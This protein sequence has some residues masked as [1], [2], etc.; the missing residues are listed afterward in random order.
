MPL[1]PEKQKSMHR[2]AGSAAL[3]FALVTGALPLSAADISTLKSGDALVLM[4]AAAHL[5]TDGRDWVVPLH[6]WVYV[7]QKSRVRR[8]AIE[9]LLALRYG[10]TSSPA[11]A[12]YLTSRVNLL[13]ADNKRGRRI[14]V[15]VGGSRF[16]LPPT[17][18][19]GHAEMLARVPVSAAASDGGRLTIRAAL[20]PGDTR[21]I[22]TSVHLI[23]LTGTS[24]ISDI[25]DTVK[26]T[27]VTDHRRMFEAT[28]YKPFEAVAGMPEAYR[29]MSTSGVPF[30][31]VS[32]SP[33]HFAT[34]LLE[35]M[36]TSGLPV[37]SIALKQMRLKDRTALDIV[38]PG[39]E[40]KPPQIEAILARYPQRQFILIGDS[41]E[42]DP[43]IYAAA[44]RQ[45]GARITQVFIRNV[46]RARRD[47]ARFTKA[48][49]GID[50]ARWVLFDDASVVAVK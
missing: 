13:L 7:P 1:I 9:Q 29:R 28:F 50:A 19:N 8:A 21:R 44:M 47:D 42:D 46:T 18:A 38:K 34:P 20:A 17:G 12:P 25:D 10:L 40:T 26:V 31:Y 37:S 23:G 11:S 48:F 5:S 22:E 36:A 3:C 6:A 33:W 35:F 32:S 43:E 2:A 45:H 16:S 39:R 27:G 49:A 4:P 24:V 14:V 30:H 15:D 41:G